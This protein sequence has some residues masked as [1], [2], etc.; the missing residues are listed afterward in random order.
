MTVNEEARILA[1][2]KKGVSIAPDR[3]ESVSTRIRVGLWI[4][5]VVFFVIL[6]GSASS[7]ASTVTIVGFVSFAVG[8]TSGVLLTYANG[9]RQWNAIVPHVN[10]ESVERRISDLKPNTSLERTREG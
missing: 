1:W 5:L 6:F 8:V 7:G 3:A 2:L 10:G 4:A 9:L